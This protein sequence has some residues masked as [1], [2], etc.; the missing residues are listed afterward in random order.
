[1]IKAL[2][3][4]MDETLCDTSR[5]N[6]DAKR[7]LAKKLEMD[8]PNL[9]D[10]KTFADSFLKGIYKV[11]TPEQRTKY[12]P[13]R[14]KHGELAYRREMTKDLL[15]ARGQPADD[16]YA[17]ALHEQFE[18]DRMAAFDFFPSIQEFLVNVRQRFTLVVITNGPEFS[19]IPKLERVNMRNYVDHIIIG[20]QEPEEKPAS[21]IFQKALRLANCRAAET[22]HFG[23]SL[24]ADILGANNQ[25]IHSVWIQHNQPLSDDPKAKPTTTL[26][27]PREIPAFV[28]QL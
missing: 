13:F 4:D 19:Q 12:Q 27:H 25:D 5:A 18:I 6:N 21:S 10:G 2:F 17:T 15:L 7:L 20:G 26:Q 1:M 14:E 9:I 22:I 8:F 28:D 24:S 23:D 16:A 11:W 3:L